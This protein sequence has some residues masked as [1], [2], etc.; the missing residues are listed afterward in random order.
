M[1]SPP[2]VVVVNATRLTHVH[3]DDTSLCRQRNLGITEHNGI[4]PHS[5]SSC[6]CSSTSCSQASGV[7][8]QK[9]ELTDCSEVFK[10]IFVV[11]AEEHYSQLLVPTMRR[12]HLHYVENEPLVYKRT[13][14]GFKF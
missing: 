1:F 13:L 11:T 5:L 9:M 4:Y 7:D 14:L 8:V 3:D 2:K 6:S 10:K 12:S